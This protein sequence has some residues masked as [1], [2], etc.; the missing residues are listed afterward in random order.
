MRDLSS[1]RRDLVIVK[2]RENVLRIAA[3]NA[4]AVAIKHED[5]DEMR[6]W[7]D[8][9]V[10]TE[11]AGASDDFLARHNFAFDP[12]LIRIN[13][14]LRERMTEFHGAKDGFEQIFL[15]RFEGGNI[16]TQRR[17]QRLVDAAAFL[18]AED[19]HP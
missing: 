3:I 19:V 14:A 5:V 10:G 1:A 2:R 18:D 8:R 13:G 15:S 17:N 7:I 9:V 4:I 11:S 6:P 16:R 12:N